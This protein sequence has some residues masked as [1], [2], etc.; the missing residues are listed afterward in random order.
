MS[1]HTL[2]SEHGPAFRGG[3]FGSGHG[4]ALR[5]GYT[6]GSGNG[7]AIQRGVFIGGGCAR[8]GLMLGSG[9]RLAGG[10]YGGGV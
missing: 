9:H 7:P 5:R 1:G 8:A 6:L 10:T 4:P 2:G 3:T